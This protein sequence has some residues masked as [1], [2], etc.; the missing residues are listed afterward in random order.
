MATWNH[1]TNEKWAYIENMLNKELDANR[2]LIPQEHILQLPEDTGI[3]HYLRV[4]E[5]GAAFEYLY[6]EIMEREKDGTKCTIGKDKAMEIALM[7]ELD[8]QMEAMIDYN[9]WPK[10]SKWIKT[11]E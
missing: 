10:F 2:H 11:Q 6:L 1:I 8:D 5:T 4:G 3:E 7:L 9:F